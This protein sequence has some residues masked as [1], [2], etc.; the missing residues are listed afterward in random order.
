MKQSISVG[1]KI[2]SRDA[3]WRFISLVDGKQPLFT[4]LMMGT[5]RFVRDPLVAGRLVSVGAGIATMI[6]VWLVALE[7]FKNK[8]IALFTSFLYLLSP[9]TL[10]YDRMALYDS[11]VAAFSIWNLYLGILL[12]RRVRLDVPFWGYDPWAWYAE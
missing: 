8:R 6:G 12:V 9:F 11:L 1:H 5:L 10:M 2:G 7:L 3:A 4:W